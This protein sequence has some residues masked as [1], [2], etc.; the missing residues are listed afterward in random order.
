MRFYM[1]DHFESMYSSILAILPPKSVLF[2][3][4]Y[5]INW[6]IFRFLPLPVIGWKINCLASE[7]LHLR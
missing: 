4:D 5:R 1:L 7:S 3:S 2:E 6:F